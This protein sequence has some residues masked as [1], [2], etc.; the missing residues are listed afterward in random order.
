MEL[1]MSIMLMAVERTLTLFFPHRP[2][3]S[4][5]HTLTFVAV[6][7]IISICFAV[8]I[9][10]DSIP[11]KPFKYRYICDIDSGVPILYPITRILVYG[12]CLFISF[13]C[14]GALLSRGNQRKARSLP[15]KPH[16]NSE[17]I[18][19]SRALHEFLSLVKL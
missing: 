1:L 2:V 17:F 19:Q 8:P 4:R 14:F 6:L 10:T 12:G 13:I 16:E 7:W 9:L 15:M 18:K 5:W 11:V 3:F